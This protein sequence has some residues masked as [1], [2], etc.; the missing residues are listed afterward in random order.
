MMKNSDPDN[1]HLGWGKQNRNKALSVPV[2]TEWI[3]PFR[4]HEDNIHICVY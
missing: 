4:C 3:V 1:Q 2:L